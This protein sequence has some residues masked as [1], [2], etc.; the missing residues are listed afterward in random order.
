VFSFS[1]AH[2]PTYFL[3]T[4][5]MKRGGKERDA[6]VIAVSMGYGH[7]RAANGLRSFAY[8]HKTILANEYE[9]IPATDQKMWSTGQGFYERASRLKHIPLLG[10]LAFGVFDWLQAIPPFYPRRDLSE[11]TLQVK[12]VYGLIRKAGW[13]KHLIDELAK[14]PKPLICTYMVPAFAAEEHGYPEDIYIVLC[15]ADIA[16]PWAPL[17]PHKSRIK[18]LAPTGRVVERL[19]LYGVPE[20]NIFLTG[21]PLSVDAAGTRESGRLEEKLSRRICH[22]DPQAIFFSRAHSMIEA[23]SGRAFCENITQKQRHAVTLTFAVGGAGAQRE[24]GGAALHSLAPKILEGKLKFILAAGVRRDVAKYY[25]LEAKA[26]GLED[27]L[28]DG[29]VQILEHADHETYFTEFNKCMAQTDILWTKPSELSF[30]AGL[31]MP[32]LMAPPV[33]TQEL[34][35]RDWL[36]QVGAGADSLDPRYANEWLFDWIEGGAL[37]RMAWNGFVNAPNH[38][39]QRI[40]EVVHGKKSSIPALPIV[41]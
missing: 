29:R 37:A 7:E 25:A 38:G 8:G 5:T 32:I 24:I 15:D 4:L 11:P 10:S 18:Y 1:L 14:N 20:R 36:L 39:A 26:A 23:L 28:A 6:Y 3:Y 19:K 17:E 2:W 35:N 40:D 30:Y 12:E 13:V 16:R 21:F 9:G 34:Y 22:L 33:G 31:G 41:V 27:A